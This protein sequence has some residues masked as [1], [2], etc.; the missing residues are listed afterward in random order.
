MAVAA[1][2]LMVTAGGVDAASDEILVGGSYHDEAFLAAQRELM[3]EPVEAGSQ[4]TVG[5]IRISLGTGEPSAMTGFTP[6]FAGLGLGTRVGGDADHGPAIAGAEE[7]PARRELWI[8][9]DASTEIAGFEI[10]WAAIAGLEN[11]PRA[12]ADGPSGFVLGGQLA[13]SGLR[14]DATFGHERDLLGL[15]G[16]R[17][18]AGLAYDFGRLDTRVSYSLV[19]TDAPEDTGVLSVGSQLTLRPGVVLRGDVAYSDDGES[20]LGSTA[21]RVGVRLNF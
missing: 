21:G 9:P 2:A 8:G 20:G 15:E 7:V 12:Q 14:F 17:V 16:N 13:V 6:R 11:A 10:G 5:G 19:E 1:C 4:V 18:T 3:R